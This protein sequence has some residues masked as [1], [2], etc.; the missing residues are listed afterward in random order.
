MKI[1]KLICLSLAFISSIHVFASYAPEYEKLTTPEATKS[2]LSCVDIQKCIKYYSAK[3]DVSES[4]VASI[5]KCE[6]SNNPMAHNLTE[7]EDSWGLSQIN[8]LAHKN[9]TK[10]QATD[11]EFAIEFMTK[12]FDKAPQMW[13]TCYKKATQVE[14]AQ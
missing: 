7:N 14:S 11:P 2:I 6:S 3:Y 13:V 4:I 1:V 9:I 5:I 12:N 10:E 8:L